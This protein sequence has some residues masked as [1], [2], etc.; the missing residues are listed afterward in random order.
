MEIR[1]RFVG[2]EAS[3]ARSW[4]EDALEDWLEG[5]GE[6]LGAGSA[7]DGSW[8][9][10]DIDFF[11]MTPETADAMIEDMKRFLQQKQTPNGTVLVLFGDDDAK[12]GEYP[13][14]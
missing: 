10:I 14:W 1:V 12:L 5:R 7:T 3:P 2:R 8:S 4:V 11:K 13:V 9:H 6:V